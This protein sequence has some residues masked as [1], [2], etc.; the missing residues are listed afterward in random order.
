[1]K[2]LVNGQKFEATEVLTSI[3][4]KMA[5][6]TVAPLT[7]ETS[8]VEEETATYDLCKY[9]KPEE[10]STFATSNETVF[11]PMAAVDETTKFVNVELY[12][13]T[14]HAQH[15]LAAQGQGWAQDLTES[16]YG[17]NSIM[18]FDDPEFGTSFN[19]STNDLLDIMDVHEYQ[20]TVVH[21]DYA[22]YGVNNDV[23][24]AETFEAT[25]TVECFKG[26]VA[27]AQ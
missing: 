22:F 7:V 4:G 19:G 20:V 21:V 14:L 16:F 5:D 17:Q 12:V 26:T 9:V 15:T 1:M 18:L 27:A 2:K 11:V 10:I 6:V 25:R 3:V 13:D 24:V 8:T 23:Q